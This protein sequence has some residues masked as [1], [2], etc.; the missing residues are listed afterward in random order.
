MLSSI[1]IMFF[2]QVESPIAIMFYLSLIADYAVLFD[3]YDS[4]TFFLSVRTSFQRYFHVSI[5]LASIINDRSYSTLHLFLATSP[6]LI[7]FS[8]SLV[9][10][11]RRQ[12]PVQSKQIGTFTFQVSVPR[13]RTFL[14][15]LRIISFLV[16]VEIF[17]PPK[18]RTLLDTT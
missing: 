17:N 3:Y 7:S 5:S 14:F 18:S 2:L 13:F 11:S 9:P 4:I 12:F 16:L 10:I 8:A 6:S 1:I 15:T